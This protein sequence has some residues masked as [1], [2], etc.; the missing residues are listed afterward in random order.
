MSLARSKGPRS[1]SEEE[2]ISLIH[3]VRAMGIGSWEVIRADPDFRLRYIY[4]P[5]TLHIGNT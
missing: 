3:G 5:F 1:W 4:M 2:E